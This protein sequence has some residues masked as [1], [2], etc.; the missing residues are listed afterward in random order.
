MQKP[1]K[2]SCNNTITTS[3]NTLE[4]WKGYLP[5]CKLVSELPPLSSSKGAVGTLGDDDC[6]L[7]LVDA[8]L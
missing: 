7:Q 4:M 2:S 1:C 3:M 8:P 6:A 5:G